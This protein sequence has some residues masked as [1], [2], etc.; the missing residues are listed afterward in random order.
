MGQLNF[1]SM[2]VEKP[3]RM[4]SCFGGRGHLLPVLEAFIF[5]GLKGMRRQTE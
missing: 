3:E 2:D 5:R 4:G 1:D